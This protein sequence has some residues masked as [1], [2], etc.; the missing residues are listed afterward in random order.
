MPIAGDK[1]Q[2]SHAFMLTGYDDAQENFILRNS[3]GAGWGN[4][5]YARVP[6]DYL[7]Y[8]ATEVI[9]VGK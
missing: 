7:N 1:Y 6:Y 3:W 2:G 4:N 5:G 8:C 9:A